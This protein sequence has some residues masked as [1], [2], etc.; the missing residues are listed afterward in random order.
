MKNLFEKYGYSFAS[1][2]ANFCSLKTM[3]LFDSSYKKFLDYYG[4]RFSVD[5]VKSI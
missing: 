2:F 5:N 3:E 4:V 1:K